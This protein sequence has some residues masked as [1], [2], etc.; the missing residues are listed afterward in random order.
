MKLLFFALRPK[1]WVKNLFIFLP[2][3]FGGK[4]FDRESSIQALAAAIIFS[5]MASSVY[6]INDVLDKTKDKLHRTKKL[7]PVAS[8][9]VSL[10]S[11]LVTAG[12]LNGTALWAGFCLNRGFGVLLLGYFALNLVYTFYLKT[13]LIIDIFCLSVFYFLRVQ[14]GALVAEV[15]LSHWIIMMTMVL[16]MFLGFNKRRGEIAVLQRNASAH[17]PVLADYNLY[18]IDQMIGVLTASI[19]VFYTLYTVDAGTILNVG[20]TNLIFSIPFVYYGIFRY[21]FLVHRRRKGEDPT[22]VILSDRPL[23]ACILA[24]ACVCAVVL[25]G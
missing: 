22:A 2:L 18:F 9:R 13:M 24:W 15:E 14:A 7:R 19:I 1:Q 3:L 6:L 5:V 20:S 12:L 4:A 23:Q 17:R 21:F 8:G 16:A 10:S 25:Y 11:A